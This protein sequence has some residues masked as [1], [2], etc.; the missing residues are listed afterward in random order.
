MLK[1]FTAVANAIRTAIGGLLQVTGPAANTTRTMTV[2]DS[3]FT[4]ARTDASQTFTGNQTVNN[5]NIVIGTGGKGI[6]FSGNLDNPGS[7]TELLSWYDEGTWTPTVV[8]FGSPTY[9]VQ[10]GKYTRI[11]NI[12]HINGKLSFSGAS[13]SD[14][15]EIHGL[16]YSS[17]S[18]SDVFQ[19]AS[20]YVEGDFVGC[21]GFISAYGMF[22]T[23]GSHLQGVKNSSGSS[24]YALASDFG[25]VVSFN[26]H[27][28]YYV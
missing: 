18:P 26:F 16:P 17:A 28:T 23:N 12:V 3:D 4:A 7:S 13:G 2:P 10:N 1:G 14:P 5:G 20:C 24:A 27:L 9:T 22:R 8:G 15:V 21:S 6:L 19:R 25:S 11:G